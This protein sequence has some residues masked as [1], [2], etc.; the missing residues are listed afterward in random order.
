MTDEAGATVYAEFQNH[1]SLWWMIPGGYGC[2]RMDWS[3]QPNPRNYSGA[4]P[5]RMLLARQ[6]TM[7]CVKA[8]L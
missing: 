1:R 8:Y 2:L 3:F 5:S 4:S 6:R 7:C